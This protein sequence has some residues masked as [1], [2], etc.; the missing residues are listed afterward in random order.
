MHAVL[1]ILAALV[2]RART[3]EGAVPRRRG[4]RRR[5]LADVARDRPAPRDRRRGRR[6]ARPADRSL[7]L[8]RRLPRA[9]RQV[10]LRRRDR[11]A[12]YAN[13]CRA[14]GLEQLDRAPDRRRG[15]GRDPRA[16]C[17]RLRDARPRRLGG[18][19]RAGDTCVAPVL[20]SPS[21]PTT[22]HFAARGVFVEAEHPEHGRF[23]QV[24]PVLAG[25]PR[26]RPC[27]SATPPRPTPTR[28]SPRPAARRGDRSAAQ[29]GSDR[30]ERSGGRGRRRCPTEVQRWIG[31]KRYEQEGEF[32]VERGYVFTTCASVE[33]G[34][35]LFWDEKAAQRAHRR[36]D[37]AAD[38][39]LGLVPPA[40]LGAGPQRGR[41]S[42]CRCTST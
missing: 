10:D 2:R 26:P 5:A 32:D 11:A 7:R 34:N 13:L 27:R 41:R 15:A 40:P 22:P 21:S 16:I 4:R 29:R 14:L 36:P 28:C 38:D 9:R 33:N 12:F 6:R 24:G 39:D 18:G 1:A 3:G 8:L 31:Q 42:R 30:D 35:P 37:R 25:P 20:E 19:A 17:A 23:R